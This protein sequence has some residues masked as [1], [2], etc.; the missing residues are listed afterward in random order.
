ILCY[1]DVQ[2]SSILLDDK[3]E[4]RLGSLSEVC[5]QEGESHQNVITKLLRFSS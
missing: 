3:F 4:V 2:A 1:R 5:R